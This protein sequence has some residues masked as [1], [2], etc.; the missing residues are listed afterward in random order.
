MCA[1]MSRHWY[2]LS[3]PCLLYTQYLT[4][5]GIVPIYDARQT[6]GSFEDALKNLRKLPRYPDEVP[7]GSC[8]V[9]AYTINT[10]GK[11]EGGSM[12]NVSFNVQWVMVLGTN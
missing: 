2:V 10:W 12:V 4:I 1:G 3:L 5:H 8:V 11:Q 9:V 6:T 7:P